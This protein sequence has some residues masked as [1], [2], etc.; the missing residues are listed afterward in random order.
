VSCTSMR[1]IAVSHGFGDCERTSPPWCISLYCMGGII[2]FACSFMTYHLASQTSYMPPIPRRFL[3][4]TSISF[5]WAPALLGNPCVY[6]AKAM[7]IKSCHALSIDDQYM[8][9]NQKE[10]CH[11]SSLLPCF[12]TKSHV[13]GPFLETRT[14]PVPHTL[15][16]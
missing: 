12:L 1:C 11:S 13:H 16:N 6:T 14:R 8:L 4:H 7:A 9:Q 5:S 2:L 3:V 10:T 15:Q